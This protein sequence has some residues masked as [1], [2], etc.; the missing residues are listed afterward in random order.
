MI[1][2]LSHSLEPVLLL[3][4]HIYGAGLTRQVQTETW[5]LTPHPGVSEA[6]VSYPKAG[7]SVSGSLARTA[8]NDRT[9]RGSYCKPVTHRCIYSTKPK[10][11]SLSSVQLTQCS[12][13]WILKMPLIV[14][15]TPAWGRVWMSRE[16]RDG[17]RRWLWVKYFASAT[18]QS[19]HMN[20]VKV[21]EGPRLVSWIH[22]KSPLPFTL[23]FV[24]SLSHRWGFLV[25]FFIMF[26]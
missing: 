1:E 24:Q 9:T 14:Q 21:S 18:T 10:C 5:P 12:L 22:D 6:W 20:A 11:L 26:F 7:R 8:S 16:K 2:I 19:H 23:Y 13:K 15:V 25:L 3:H 17:G 4:S